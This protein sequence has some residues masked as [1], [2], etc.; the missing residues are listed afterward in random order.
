MTDENRNSLENEDFSTESS[1]PID[2]GTNFVNDFATSDDPS[3][4]SPSTPSSDYSSE[5]P[6]N[7][8]GTLPSAPSHGEL[9]HCKVPFAPWISEAF[10][11]FRRYFWR[12]LFWIGLI[13]LVLTFLFSIFLLIQEDLSNVLEGLITGN[14][15]LAENGGVFL[16]AMILSLITIIW[17]LSIAHWSLRTIQ[18]GVPSWKHLV[19]KSFWTVPKVIVGIFVLSISLG[20]LYS[21]GIFLGVSF[22]KESSQ[23]L[24]LIYFILIFVGIGYLYLRYGFFFWFILDRN[25]GPL[26]SLEESSLF[27]KKNIGV[28]LRGILF[29]MGTILGISFFIGLF[30]GFFIRLFF[31]AISNSPALDRTYSLLGQII[32]QIIQNIIFFPFLLG[33]FTIFYLM[34]T[35]Q[36]RPGVWPIE[37]IEESAKND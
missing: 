22:I 17:N 31:N 19:F 1:S 32:G 33:L 29:V 2:G 13:P 14:V 18:T 37:N 24:N 16:I 5:T 23:I 28:L 35:G 4:G 21:G 9:T 10:V 7:G 3:T 26:K 20:V 8:E 12:R 15:K 34:M 25:S 6:S 27:M 36:E 30:I 11:F